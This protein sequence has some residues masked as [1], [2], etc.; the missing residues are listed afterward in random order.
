M[1]HALKKTL[2]DAL[3]KLHTGRVLVVGDVV[4]DEMVYGQT[5]RLSREAPVLILHHN[6]T[7]ILLGGA[8]NA[9]HNVA[10]LG[11]ARTVLVGVCGKDYHAGL[12]LD[13]L[14]RDGIDATAM[15]QDAQRP[16]T[17][18]T[19]ISGMAN[20]SVT[21]Q[22]V[23]IDR[24]S[25]AAV[26]GKIE[27]KLLDNISHWAPQV[28]AL[29]LSD[30]GLGVLTD[31]VIEH[32]RAMAQTHHLILAADSHQPLVKFKGATVLTP[33][34]PEAEQNVGYALDTPEKV[35]EGGQHLL[36]QC[37]AKNVLMTR[38]QEG[39]VL[40]SDE[41]SLTRIPA[42]N[43]S[44]VFDVTGAGDTVIATLTLAMASGVAILPAAILGNLAASIV[45][46]QFGAATTT[47]EAMRDVLNDLDDAVLAGIQTQAGLT[48]S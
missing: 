43:R 19:R 34:Q 22:I 17:T 47:T 26:S 28:D 9:A 20:Q 46:K 33:N 12:L 11:A 4:I 24:E 16:T 37:Q 7:D 10:K 32:C 44:E 1:T 41:G 5:A 14:E 15:V 39:M 36:N 3:T 6:R 18:K 31:A 40:M 29:L 8:G 25:P 38:G 48:T 45:V 23:R 35:R 27:K 21:Q 2:S 42:F 30:Y 13:A